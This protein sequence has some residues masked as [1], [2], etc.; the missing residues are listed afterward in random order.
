ME[1]YFPRYLDNILEE[2]LDSVGAVLIVG[3]Y[4]L[5]EFKLGNKQIEES[6]KHLLK[7]KELISNAKNENKNIKEPDLLMIITGGEIA[8]TREDGIKV[9]PIGCLKA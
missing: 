8:Y 5:I 7:L 2:M 1:Q 3:C 4:A 6:A 9:V